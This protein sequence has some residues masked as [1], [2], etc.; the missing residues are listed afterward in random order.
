M[1]LL[2]RVQRDLPRW[3]GPF[4][5]IFPSIKDVERL[6]S[7]A[8][9]RMDPTQALLISAT[10][11]IVF[12]LLATGSTGMVWA[13]VPAAPLGGMILFVWLKV[14]QGRRYR[15]FGEGFPDALELMARSASA[16]H[17]L[18]GTIG[19]VA[20]ESPEP[21]ASEFQR[22]SD[23]QKYGMSLRESLLG[24]GERIDTAD[25]RMFSTAI[26]L[27]R[28]TG[29]NLADTLHNLAYLMRERV[30]LGREVK[31]RSAHARMTGWVLGLTPLV[32]VGLLQLVNP[33]YI[34]PLLTQMPGQALLGAAAL[35]QGFGFLV[36]HRIARL[37]D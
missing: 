12:A 4:R 18:P 24:L 15:A 35:L 14:R 32:L 19:M 29:G 6:I 2:R 33:G 9:S 5:R 20:E 26:L 21:L 22:V 10:L 31:T 17:A 13:A 8:G 37:E 11:A 16:G 30:K 34:A 36:I 27:H 3:L 23:E 1:S 25:M 7:R 28:E